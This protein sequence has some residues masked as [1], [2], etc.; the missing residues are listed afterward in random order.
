MANLMVITTYLKWNGAEFVQDIKNFQIADILHGSIQISKLE[1]QII[2]THAFNRLHNVLQ[3]STVFLTF[4]SNQTKRFAH[5]L[6]VLHLGG[7]MFQS[8][9]INAEESVRDRFFDKINSEIS[10]IFQDGVFMRMLR[11]RL[12]PYLKE[13]MISKFYNLQP[14]DPLYSL[15]LP[16]CLKD[17][18][19]FAYCLMYQSVRCAALLHDVGHPPFSH[20]AEY[21]M[22]EV[23]D[24]I[25]KIPH[26]QLTS[27]HRSFLAIT[28]RYASKKGKIDLHEKIGNRI[29]DRLLEHLIRQHKESIK[30]SED[31]EQQL[32]YLLVNQFTTFILEDKKS[33]QGPSIFANV[34]RI[35]DGSID[36]DRLDYVTR[37]SISSVSGKGKIEYDRLVNSM[38]LMQANDGSFVFSFD[39]RTLSSIEDFF[40]KRWH[41]YKYIIYHHR[42]IKTDALLGKAI[43]K[44]SLDYLSEDGGDS[45]Q[46]NK[47]TLP[48]DISG[49]WRA[50]T[51][52]FSDDDYF[53]ALIQW[54]DSWLLTVLRQKYF[55]DYNDSTEII[56]QQLEELLSNKKNYV[57]IVK[58]MDDFYEIDNAVLNCI[59][60]D[61]DSLN[62]LYRTISKSGHP[63]V[64][65]A[66]RLVSQVKDFRAQTDVRGSIQSF[67][68]FL[69]NLLLLTDSLSVEN[70][71]Q[72]LTDTIKEEVSRTGA[73]DAIVAF[74][75]LK[76]GLEKSPSIHYNNRVV[77]LSN[78]SNIEN[79]FNQNKALFP[80]FF[81][82][83]CDNRMPPS[84]L[85]ES[86][87]SKIGENLI[88]F[89]T[90]LSEQVES[91]STSG[92][93]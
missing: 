74:K 56:K 79:E 32:F 30:S 48:L 47:Q 73:K 71:D 90:Q 91:Q 25:K 60:Q 13:E 3:N 51:D 68:F 18:Q 81:L 69:N 40:N 76:T 65:L 57:S 1:K 82:Y 28:D 22:K 20:I 26:E 86:I 8:S 52:L 4:P 58:R 5:S 62:M 41:L 75:K 15:K 83:V 42:V 72:I 92:R 45:S 19:K 2:S 70:I 88:S 44:L 14:I 46:H 17:T 9:I 33:D 12:G 7:E 53:N 84:V 11:D 87:G 66:E 39:L 63:G 21:A 78:I 23:I 16:S 54:D 6:G 80:T 64:K 27:R 85:R 31:A 35:V 34:H 50:I 24:E 29:S 36:C 55:S 37:D 10:S 61:S 89:F 38:K 93:V 59:Q 43:V 67:G 77:P 49:L